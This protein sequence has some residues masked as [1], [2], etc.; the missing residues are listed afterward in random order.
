MSFLSDRLVGVLSGDVDEMT[1]K[2]ERME[3]HKG[4]R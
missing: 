2:R 1:T 4:S 3:R